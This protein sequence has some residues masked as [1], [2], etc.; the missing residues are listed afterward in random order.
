IFINGREIHVQDQA[1]L[2]QIFGVTYT[3]RYWLDA[4]GNLGIEGGGI[5]ANLHAA[6]QA[7]AGRQYGSVTGAGGT[8]AVDGQGGAMFSAR[9]LDGKS[10]FWYSGQ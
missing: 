3:G 10:I 6:M 7:T 1:A 9:T 8:A 2:Q 5:I 4:Q